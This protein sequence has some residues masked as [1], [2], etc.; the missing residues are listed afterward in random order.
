MLTGQEERTLAARRAGLLETRVCLRANRLL[1]TLDLGEIETLDAFLSSRVGP[2]AASHRLRLP[3]Y[4]IPL[5]AREGLIRLSDN[6]YIA[7]HYGPFEIDEAEFVRFADVLRRRAPSSDLRDPVS[8]RVAARAIGGGVKPWGAIF[9]ELIT[10]R[11]PF[12]MK[13]VSI[14][15]IFLSGSDAARIRTFETEAEDDV[16]I[17]QVSQRDAIEILNLPL[18]HANLLVSS[19]KAGQ[20]LRRPIDY[21]LTLAR[22]R[23]TLAELSARTAIHPARLEHMLD[24]QGCPR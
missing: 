8:L 16:P 2:E 4:A 19:P 23:V 15:G 12:V 9:R 18:K 14:E 13:K 1:P 20:S 7:H 11:I 21:V 5:L 10:G 6:P 22:T 17:R 24:K 3:Q